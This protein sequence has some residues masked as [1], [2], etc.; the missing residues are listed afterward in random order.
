MTLAS[1]T[2]WP[3]HAM[4]AGERKAMLRE[5]WAAA[6]AGTLPPRQPGLS[7]AWAAIEKGRRQAAAER[8][9]RRLDALG[10]VLGG[11]GIVA[12][13]AGLIWLVAP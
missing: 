4:T 12:F 9:S 11:L 2:V 7:E 3:E 1:N 13:F 6:Y 8:R 10:T 5:H